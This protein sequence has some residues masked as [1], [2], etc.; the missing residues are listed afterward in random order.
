MTLKEKRIESGYTQ[1]ELSEKAGMSLRTLQHFERNYRL[2]DKA[3]LETLCKLAIVLNCPIDDLIVND[4]LRELYRK[5]KT[6]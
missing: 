4:D 2:P 5:A 1:S 3:Q 6:L